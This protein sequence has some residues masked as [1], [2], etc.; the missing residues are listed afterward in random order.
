MPTLPSAVQATKRPF[1]MI[2]GVSTAND[3]DTAPVNCTASTLT[4]TEATHAGRVI[5]LNL[6][7]GIA[8]TLP[9]ST[10]RGAVYRFFVGTTFTGASSIKVA[11]ASDSFLGNAVLFNDGGAT[12][13]GFSAV[14]N[15]DT[16]DLLGTSNSTGGLI[17]E[18]IEIRDV[19]LN[20]FSV[21]L[22]TDAGGT[23]ATP[24]SAT[25]S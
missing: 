15:D 22:V 6:A 10:G 19:A 13:S 14:A 4:V 21:Q 11:N 3:L 9:A 23:E 5:T 24:F 25:V 1:R 2:R 18:Y 12:V 17:G 16:I 7:A 20:L 8:V